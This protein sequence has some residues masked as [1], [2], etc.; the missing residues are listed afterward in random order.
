[1]LKSSFAKALFLV[2]LISSWVFADCVSCHKG[3]E[4]IRHQDSDM[5]Q[6][7]KALGAGLGDPAGCTMSWW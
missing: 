2:A 4:D 1:M 3:I 6:Q 7:I 5:M